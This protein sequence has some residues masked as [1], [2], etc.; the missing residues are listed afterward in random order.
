MVALDS[1]PGADTGQMK[2]EDA[3]LML[4]FQEGEERCFEVLFQRHKKAMTSFAY[5]F[6]GRWDVAEELSQE[7]FVKCYLAAPRYRP[8]AKFT[9]WLYRITRN[10]CLNEVRRQDYRYRTDPL[11]G[12]P[13]PARKTSPEDLTRARLLQAAVNRA[14]GDLPEK[15]RTALVLSRHHNMSYQEISATLGVS[16]SAVK[17]L[18]NRAKASLTDGLSGFLEDGDEL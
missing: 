14:L 6:T 4:A 11:E 5:R 8:R 16:L 13:E 17:S 9:T 7:I 2:D 1:Q 18:L 15:Q 12:G 3:D 10:H